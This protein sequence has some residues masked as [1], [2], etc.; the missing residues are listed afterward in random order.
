MTSRTSQPSIGRDD[1]IRENRLRRAAQRQGLMLVKS[2]RRDRRA[3]DYGLFVLV[4]DTIGN[5]VGPR[6]GQ[7][8]VS[9]FARGEGMDLDGIE[10]ELG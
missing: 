5:K 2:R 1:K 6:G 3:E 10:R 4:D 7:A 9:A 8:A